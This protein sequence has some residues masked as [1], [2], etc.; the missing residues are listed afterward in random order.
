MAWTISGIKW[1]DVGSDL[2][3]TS[4]KYQDGEIVDHSSESKIRPI[5]NQ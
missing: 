3:P 1:M 2:L 5:W 4:V